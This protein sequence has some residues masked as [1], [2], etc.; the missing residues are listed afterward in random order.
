MTEAPAPATAASPEGASAAMER[1]AR[2]QGPREL[3]A[4]ILALLLPRGSQRARRAWMA[5]TP[6]IE[7]AAALRDAVKSLAPGARLPFFETLLERL[8]VQ[9]MGARQDLIAATRRVMAARGAVRPIDRLHWL[10]MRKALTNEE[11]PTV[12]GGGSADVAQWLQSEVM[13]IAGMSAYLSR[14]V[15]DEAHGRDWY[16]SVVNPWRAHPELPAHHLPD[17]EAMVISYDSLL[18]LG[19]MQ[20]PVLVRHWVSLAID[21][22]TQTRLDET[23]ADALRLMALLLDCPLPPELARQFVARPFVGA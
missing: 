9:P 3:H 21:H 2:V 23:A 15:P 14:M 22:G 1:L 8:A 7:G 11:P 5:E 13:A 12:R 4:A 10:L 19:W 17:A 20:R 6:G 18:A 16:E